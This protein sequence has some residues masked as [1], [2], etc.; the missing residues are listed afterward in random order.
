M[1]V[2]TGSKILDMVITF[3]AFLVMLGFLIAIFIALFRFIFKIGKILF[4]LASI[5]VLLVVNVLVYIYLAIAFIFNIFRNLIGY[6]TTR[7]EYSKREEYTNYDNSQN[8]RYDSNVDEK[9]YYYLI[10]GLDRTAS[11]DEIKTAYRQL[12]MKYHPDTNSSPEA[13]MKYQEI[14]EA[15]NIL[16]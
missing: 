4:D 5:P 15:R 12:A 8:D 13:K 14:M 7:R 1:L 3:A 11:K 10:L 6:T 16:L 2:E 9:A